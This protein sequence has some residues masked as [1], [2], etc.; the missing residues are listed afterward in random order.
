[1]LAANSN[2]NVQPAPPISV[3]STALDAGKLKSIMNA[4]T[5]SQIV[6][7]ALGMRKRNARKDVLNVDLLKDQLKRAGE[8]IVDEEYIKFW[9]DLQAAGIGAYIIGRRGNPNRFKCHYSIKEVTSVAI[10]GRYVPKK[11]VRHATSV[12]KK[13]GKRGPG[14]PKGYSPKKAK[15]VKASAKRARLSP[16]AKEVER[17]ILQTLRQALLAV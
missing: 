1:M 8:K 13:P 4:T 10:E 2:D 14:R 6:M 9:M 5:T 17:R 3:P 12:P 7:V 11:E 16:E 15:A